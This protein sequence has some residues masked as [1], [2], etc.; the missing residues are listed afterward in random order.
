MGKTEIVL[1]NEGCSI[2]PQHVFQK[3]YVI[4]IFGKN[5]PIVPHN[6]EAHIGAVHTLYP[7]SGL[8]QLILKS[9][10]GF[11]GHLHSFGCRTS[12]KQSHQ[13]SQKV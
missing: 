13:Y 12:L 3:L 2:L 7:I 1:L 11:G 8:H 9:S 6:I 10:I 4:D 5:V